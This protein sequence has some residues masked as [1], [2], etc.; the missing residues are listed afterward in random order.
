[1]NSINTLQ[2]DFLYV[3]GGYGLGYYLTS[4]EQKDSTRRHNHI[5]IDITPSLALR[6]FSLGANYP[7]ISKNNS[8]MYSGVQAAAEARIVFFSST[9]G[10]ITL[11]GKSEYTFAKEPLTELSSGCQISIRSGF[12]TID[13]ST[14]YSRTILSGQTQ[15]MLQGRFGATLFL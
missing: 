9:T 1:M 3:R 8:V 15:D 4:S 10:S 6:S 13:L 11:Y 2:H 7:D 5:G 14:E 12:G